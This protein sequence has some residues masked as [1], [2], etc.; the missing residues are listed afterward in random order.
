MG[1]DELKSSLKCPKYR[2]CSIFSSTFRL[3]V[4][5]DNRDKLQLHIKWGAES[6][7]NSDKWKKIL[8]DK[9]LY[10]IHVIYYVNIY[11]WYVI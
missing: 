7:R 11:Y 2:I 1:Q 8:L 4:I 5:C 9:F 10:K 6:M 3:Q